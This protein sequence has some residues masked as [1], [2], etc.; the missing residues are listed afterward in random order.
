MSRQQPASQ[1]N[2]LIK[3]AVHVG[4]QHSVTQAETFNRGN[5][6]LSVIDALQNAGFAVELHSCWRNRQST[7]VSANIDTLIK[8]SDAAYDPASIAFSL[9]NDAFQ[10][11]L[12]WRLIDSLADTPKS[13]HYSEAS[14]LAETMGNGR[15][16]DFSDFDIHYGYMLIGE[17]WETRASALKYIADQTKT[18]LAKMAT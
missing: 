18:Q 3:M 5:A 6:V 11:R 13:E 2:R 1:P 9:C 14:K 12:V 16:A 15:A 10:R 8:A 4:K 17:H 7:R